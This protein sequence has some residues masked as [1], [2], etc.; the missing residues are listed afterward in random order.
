MLVNCVRTTVIFKASAGLLIDISRDHVLCRS[1]NPTSFHQT[2]STRDRF[3]LALQVRVADRV[4][5]RVCNHNMSR[6]SLDSSLCLAVDNPSVRPFAILRS[7]DHSRLAFSLGREVYR[8][9]GGNGI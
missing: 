1:Q 9:R 3:M 2:I 4:S 5:A 7:L 6:K 8:T